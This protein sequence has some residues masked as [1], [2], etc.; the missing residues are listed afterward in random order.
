M[1]EANNMYNDVKKSELDIEVA[2]LSKENAV[3]QAID[4]ASDFFEKN[5]TDPI[6]EQKEEKTSRTCC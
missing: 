1:E 2:S 6:Q 5:Q 3:A 4:A